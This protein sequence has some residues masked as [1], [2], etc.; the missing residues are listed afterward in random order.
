[1][2]KE[3]KQIIS[4][5]ILTAL[6]MLLAI[7]SA[8]VTEQE[9]QIANQEGTIT[10]L[11]LQIEDLKTENAELEKKYFDEKQ[12]AEYWYYYNVDDAC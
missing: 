2:N 4:L 5:I 8:Q 7:L 10:E 9:K 11:K 1:M 3:E 6:V 12:A